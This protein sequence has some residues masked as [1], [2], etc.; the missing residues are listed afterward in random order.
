[1]ITRRQLLLTGAAIGG[2]AA[3][4]QLAGAQSTARD[5][6]ARA[7]DESYSGG[8]V[9]RAPLPPGEPGRDYTPVV[10]PNGKALP[11]KIVDGVKVF[12]LIAEELEHEFAPG[13]TA[14]C[15]GYNG[16]VNSTLIEA[17]EGE[18][19]RFYV[20]NRLAVPTTVHWHGIFLPNGMDGVSGLNQRPIAP[21]ETFKY[22]W[23]LRQHGTFMYHSHHDTMTQEG[24]GLIGMFI[25]HPR[26]PL[27]EERV[28][29]DFV[30]LLSEWSI[31]PGV[32]RPD[33]NEMTDFNVLTM[34]G[35]CSPGIEPLV[36]KLGDRVRI[37]FGNL[38]QMDAHPIHLHGH[39]FKIA[40]TDGERIRRS[41]RW[42]ETTVVIA[43]GQTRE[44]E[45]IADA[46]GDWAMHCHM[47]HHVMNQMGHEFPNMIGMKPGDLD[48]RVRSLLPGYMTMGQ[49]GMGGMGEMGMAMPENS[50]PMGGAE[51]PFSHLG[52]GGMFTVLKVREGLT[53]YDDPGWF[54]HPEG[55]VASAASPEE[56]RRDLGVDPSEETRPTIA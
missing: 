10:M 56:L 48:Q 47:T 1:M 34:N 21:G 50:I 30:I 4:P 36:T 2:G 37:R 49:G 29:R 5:D 24:M 6:P 52:M 39:R 3:L 43:A 51:G 25:V 20:T 16:R 7:W 32:S 31:E 19:V 23:T 55:T 14:T 40:A 8:S 9:D 41:A 42:P 53:S 12:H 33:P 54:D 11:W 44:I 17:V 38:S 45:F 28:D 27:P 35:R 18:R 46:P 13:L 26:N 22:E 15:W